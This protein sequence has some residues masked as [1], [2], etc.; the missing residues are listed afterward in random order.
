MKKIIINL[1]IAIIIAIV[2]A[3]TSVE[4][5]ADT[6]VATN[7]AVRVK[8][9]DGTYKYVETYRKDDGTQAKDEWIQLADKTGTLVWKYY[10]SDGKV[11]TDTTTPDGSKVNSRG[12]WYIN[13]PSATICDV[14][15]YFYENAY[16]PF[17]YDGT[18]ARNDYLGVTMR[19][20]ENDFLG[21]YTLNMIDTQRPMS[22]DAFTITSPVGS[23]ATVKII[24]YDGSSDEWINLFLQ[25][26]SGGIEATYI[27]IR[28][29]DKLFKGISK[30]VTVL[31]STRMV[32][33]LYR[34]TPNGGSLQI[35]IEPKTETD[36]IQI[37]NWLN[38]HMTFTK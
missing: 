21:G 6:S 14:K 9:E 3:S 16:F 15:D 29:A 34:R 24:S 1:T 4:I 19:Y 27:E 7:D 30:T 13:C 31:D 18:T 5:F 10:G 23:K 32:D 36:G 17:S 20:D 2:S 37:L 33:R 26:G 11:L 22:Y 8:Q 35:E 12:E 28:I 25:P 38:E